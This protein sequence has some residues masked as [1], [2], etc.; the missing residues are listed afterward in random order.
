MGSA[1]VIADGRAVSVAV[2][3][4]IWSSKAEGGRSLLN[5]IVYRRRGRRD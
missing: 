3:E 1:R 4:S 5:D 2:R